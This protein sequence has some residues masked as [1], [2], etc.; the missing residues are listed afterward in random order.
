MIDSNEISH[1]P[2]PPSP[3]KKKKEEKDNAL[4]IWTLDPVMGP[5]DISLA[6]KVE[7]FIDKDYFAGLSFNISTPT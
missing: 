7:I 4:A 3:P 2:P 1:A 6:Q 5:C